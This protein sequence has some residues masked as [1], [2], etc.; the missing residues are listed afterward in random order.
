MPAPASDGI[1]LGAYEHGGLGFGHA[2]NACLGEQGGNAR[3]F[4]GGG[5]ATGEM[6]EQRKRVRLAAAKLRGKVENGVRLRALAGQ[7]TDDFGS[8]DSEVVGEVS[9]LEEPLRLLVIGGRTAFAHLVEMDGELRC[10][11]RFA[12]AQILAR[13]DNFI[14]GFERHGYWC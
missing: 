3:P 11:E 4:V 9:S 12:F 7:A 14:P 5:A 13:G 2:R 10:V 6:V 8:E 1:K